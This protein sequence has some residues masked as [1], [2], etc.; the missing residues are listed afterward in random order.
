MSWKDPREETSAVDGAN[1][2]SADQADVLP[3]SISFVDGKVESGKDAGA[4]HHQTVSGN[5][6]HDGCSR[7][8]RLQGIALDDRKVR[9][10][11]A[12]RIVAIHVEEC[13]AGFQL[14]ICKCAMHGKKCGGFDAVSFDERVFH[15]ADPERAVRCD[16]R[17]CFFAFLRCHLLAV[18][19]HD[20]RLP[21]AAVRGPASAGIAAAKELTCQ[22]AGT[23]N[24]RSGQSASS[25]FVDAGDDQ[26]R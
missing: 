3:S 25:G 24:N 23:R 14:Q 18:C 17:I 15:D 13:G 20:I 10:R 16:P 2:V 19:D 4:S 8:G 22:D 9:E 11:K 12:K 7:N 6:C 5:F 26:V 21:P 1:A